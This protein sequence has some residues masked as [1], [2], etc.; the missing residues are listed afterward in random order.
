M[1]FEIEK[2]LL[3]EGMSKIVSIT[4]RRSP[5]P[6]LTHALIE[7]K[8]KVL[9]ITATD[10]EVGIRVNYN[11]IDGSDGLAT[12]PARKFMEIVRELGSGPIRIELGDRFRLKVTSGRSSFDLA[13]MDPSDF[14]AWSS[15]EDIQTNEI[16]SDKLVH[17][18]EKTIFASSNDDSRFNLN[19]VL[20]EK[21][22]KQTRFV[23]TDGHRLALID[24]EIDM[25]IPSKVIVPKKGL[26]ELKRLLESQK[27]NVEIGFERKNLIL[28]SSKAMMTIRLIEGDYPD[29]LRVLPTDTAITISANKPD[30]LQCLKRMAILTSDRNKGVNICIKNGQMEFS[31]NH[32][33][34]GAANDVI[35]VDYNYELE[36][37]L[38]LNVFYMIDAIGNLD[39]DKILI[40]YYK[41]GAPIKFLNGPD[42]NYFSIVMPMRK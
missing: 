19:G 31:V 15:T 13:G 26:M 20:I 25:S 37:I 22:D 4:E 33:D 42:S 38:I 29:Y 41:D 14:P 12:I 11:C 39:S 2:E 40:E 3:S 35:E 6:I 10:L 7:V 21:N 28:K 18:L 32:P 9:S 30:L 36:I 23:A 17:M 1:F 8:E 27:E 24:E 34:L 16:T 5:L